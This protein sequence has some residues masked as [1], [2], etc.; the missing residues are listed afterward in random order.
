MEHHEE[1]RV[2]ANE[3][4]PRTKVASLD[5][6]VVEKGEVRSITTR[7]GTPGRVCDA[8]GQD[9]EGALVSLSLWNDEIDRVNINDRIRIVNGWV[10]EWRGNVQVSAG[11]YGKLEVLH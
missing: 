9:E 4:K 8:K 1:E 6:T 3:L 7:E 5:L 11:R 10:S 2:K